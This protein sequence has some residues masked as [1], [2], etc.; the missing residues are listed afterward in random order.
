M[1]LARNW[2]KDTWQW[3]YTQ[4]FVIVFQLIKK[5]RMKTKRKRNMISGNS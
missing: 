1:V 2:Q 5:E 4:D 3:S